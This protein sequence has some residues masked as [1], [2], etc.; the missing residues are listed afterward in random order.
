MRLTRSHTRAAS[1][2]V[3]REVVRRG[4][5]HNRNIFF[6]LGGF[7]TQATLCKYERDRYSIFVTLT[8]T[9]NQHCQIRERV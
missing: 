3:V 1:L 7:R 2:H 8:L 5:L 9:I 6:F 4:H